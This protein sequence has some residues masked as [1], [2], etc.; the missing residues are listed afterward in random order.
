MSELQN[1]RYKEVTPEETVK[2]LKGLLKKLGIEVVEK[3]SN[4]SSVGTYSLRVCIKGTDIGQNGKGMTKEFAMASGYAEF[5]ERMQNGMFRFRMEKATTEIPFVNAPDEKHLTVKEALNIHETGKIKN[6]FFENIVKQNGKENSIAEEQAQFIKKI[7][8]EK[9]NLVEKEEYN[10]LPYYSV[11]NK[12]LE[13]VPDRLFSYLFDTN[14]M[15]AGNSKEEAL[16]EGLSEILERYVGVKIFKEKVTL[17]EIPNTYI[18]KFPK[19]KKMVDKLKQSTEYYFRLVDCSFGGK[20]PVAG[21]YIIEKNTGKFGFKMG[22]HP[23][24]GIAMERCFTEAAQGRDIYEY[25]ETCLFDFYSGEDS[26]NRNLSE[27]I[28]SDLTAV[29]FQVIGEKSDF[30]FTEMP[31]V[32]ELDNKTLLKKLVGII[33]EEG[34]DIL[35]RDVS[36]LGFPAFSIAIPGMSEI[37]FDPDAT[38]FNLFVTMQRLLKDFGNITLENV[39]EVIKIMEVIVNQIGYEKLSILVSLKDTSVLP[40]EQIGE[41][42]KYFLAICYIMDKQY[43]KAAKMLEDLSFLADNIMENPIERI[44]LKAV[45]YYASAMD[46]LQEHEKAMYYINILF[47][48]EIANCIDISFKDRKNILV[49][50]YE[51]TQDDYV[52]NDDSFYMPFMKKIRE[53]QRDNIINQEENKEIFE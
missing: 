21:L 43:N 51:V 6:S 2:K 53:A 24:Y 50:H 22:A 38:Y 5:F 49:N 42:A 11:K 15:C 20:Y 39:K 14:G 52:D 9:S 45:Y 4:E 27:F 35:V 44:M 31:D 32:S 28:F 34:K 18:E 13:Y 37:S 40:C 41:G 48:E 25:A 26:K 36:T 1:R 12:D 3:W 19:V 29:P 30:E 17:P 7:L 33:L 16:I 10:Y 8:N 46:K 23:D 47:D